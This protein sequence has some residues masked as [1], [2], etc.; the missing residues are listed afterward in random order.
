MASR[1]SGDSHEGPLDQRS[2][3]IDEEG[4]NAKADVDDLAIEQDKPVATG[5]P[6]QP[7]ATDGQDSAESKKSSTEWSVELQV[8]GLAGRVDEM[9]DKVA[10]NGIVLA[11]ILSLLQNRE[12]DY[13]SEPSTGTQENTHRFRFWDFI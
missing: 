5:T 1:E 7:E 2:Q 10:E 13:P 4:F 6:G 11:K 8:K 9:E 12:R 3:G